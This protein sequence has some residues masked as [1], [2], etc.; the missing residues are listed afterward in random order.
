MKCH[1]GKICKNARGLKIHQSKT[2]CGIGEKQTQRIVET[3]SEM[4]E[5]TNQKAPHSTEDLLL[6]VPLQSQRRDSLNTTP[7]TQSLREKVKWPPAKDTTAW[8]QLDQDLDRVLEA[9]LAGTI[10]RKIESMAMIVIIMA[11]ERFGTEE[12][13]GGSRAPEKKPNRQAREIL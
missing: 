2:T 3:L 5:D 7:F 12:R 8:T 10:E 4:Q 11:K 13:I 9:T 1:C 6:S